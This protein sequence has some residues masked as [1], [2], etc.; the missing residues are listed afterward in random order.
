MKRL[1][2]ALG[3]L[4]AVMTVAYGYTVTRRERQY[5]QLVAE[6][7]ISLVRG[8]LGKAVTIFE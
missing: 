6:G 4:L 1:I 2:L 5:R 8:D 3:I 7:D